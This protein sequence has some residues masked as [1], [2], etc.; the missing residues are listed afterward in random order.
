MPYVL[1]LDDVTDMLVAIGLPPIAVDRF[2]DHALAVFEKRPVLG[3]VRLYLIWSIEHSAW[4]A[5]DQ[6]GY[7]RELHQ[8]GYYGEADS[9]EIVARANRRTVNECRIPVAC[10]AQEVSDGQNLSR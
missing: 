8:A 3:P 4:W 6:C 2:R 1:T 10:V 5:A 7:T 9:R